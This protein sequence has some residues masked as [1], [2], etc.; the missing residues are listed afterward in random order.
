[1]DDSGTRHPTRNPGRRPEHGHDWFALGGVLFLEEDEKLIREAHD[2]FVEEWS[3]TSPL[4][5]SEIR[6]RSNSFSFVGKLSAKE[7]TRFY[8][9][10]YCMMRDIPVIGLSCVI[11]R[12]GYCERYL[13]KY[14]EAERW[15]ICKTAFCISVERATKYAVSLK[16]TLR[17]YIEKSDK[18]TDAR[19][20]AYYEEL[21]EQGKSKAYNPVEQTD[22]KSSLYE[23]R[24]KAKS[25]PLMQLAD[26]YLWP[27]CIGGYDCKNRPYMRMLSDKKLIDGL[28][29]EHE[30]RS[31][32]IKYSCFGN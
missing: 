22:F 27:Q 32:G 14:S 5:S 1:M 16:R 6:A 12:P 29:E 3:I 9:E 21:K 31:L 17:V 28:L 7:Q 26:L 10:L 30:I 23:F 20:K 18:K 15:E 25:S 4:H 11:D 13:H 19:V 8:E 24:V 2:A